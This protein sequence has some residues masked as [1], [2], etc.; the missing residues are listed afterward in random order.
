MLADYY[1]RLISLIVLVLV[2]AFGAGAQ[3]VVFTANT[4]AAK[5]GL[6]DQ[7]EVTYTIRDAE[8]LRTMSPGSR[9][10]CWG[11]T[12]STMRHGCAAHE[13]SSRSES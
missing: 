4:N 6:Q 3:N 10:K 2:Q 9:L 5:I 11:R 8:N 12:P 1:T 13:M 7:V